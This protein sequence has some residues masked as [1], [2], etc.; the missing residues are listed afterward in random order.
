MQ[1]LPKKHTLRKSLEPSEFQSLVIPSGELLIT[2]LGKPFKVLY[3]TL[4]NLF[5]NYNN[6]EDL[7]I[8]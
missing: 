6:K 2:F 8:F 3:K 4:N 5:L 1:S 7:K